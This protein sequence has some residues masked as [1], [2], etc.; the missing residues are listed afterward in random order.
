MTK[1]MKTGSINVFAD[2]QT[3]ISNIDNIGEA[4]LVFVP[5]EPVTTNGSR[6]LM[7]GYQ[8]CG[9]SNTIS[10]NSPDANEVSTDI[11]IKSGKPGT[12]FTKVVRVTNAVAVTLETGWSWSGGIV[13]TITA[14][15]ILICLQCGTGGI[16]QFVS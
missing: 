10:E 9:T 14:G 1:D 7:A 5:F 11:T 16:V 12:T 4:D 8:L 13:P 3:F 6:G 2:E 15:G